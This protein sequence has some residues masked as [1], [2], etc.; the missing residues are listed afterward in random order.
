MAGIGIAYRVGYFQNGTP[1]ASQQLPG[2]V[3]ASLPQKAEHRVSETLLEPPLQ[4][5]FVEG[6]LPA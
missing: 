5:E 3:H 4:L 1:A 6:E 2:S